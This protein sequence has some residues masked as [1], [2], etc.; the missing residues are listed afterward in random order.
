MASDRK[1]ENH[2]F[3]LIVGIIC[4]IILAYIF[5]Y[6]GS[7]ISSGYDLSQ[8]IAQTL[9]AILNGKFAYTLRI[10]SIYGFVFAACVAFVVYFLTRVNTDAHTTDKQVESSFINIA[11]KKTPIFCKW[12]MN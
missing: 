11:G 2:T 7:Y 6:I 9:Q 4:G 5:G 12:G 8:S 1:K 3:A 10:Q